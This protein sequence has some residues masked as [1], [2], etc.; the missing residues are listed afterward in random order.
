MTPGPDSLRLPPS[1]PGRSPVRV[2]PPPWGP[3]T[4][5]APGSARLGMELLKDLLGYSLAVSGHLASIYSSKGITCSC[6]SSSGIVCLL[7]A[8]PLLGSF[9]QLWMQGLGPARASRSPSC[10][11]TPAASPCSPPFEFLGTGPPLGQEGVLDGTWQGSRR[12]GVPGLGWRSS[13]GGPGA[14]HLGSITDLL[15]PGVA[16]VVSVLAAQ[17]V[18]P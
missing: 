9:L 11:W 17:P 12:G 15:S 14:E 4:R 13:R 8:D 16:P 18:G 10:S 3:E 5:R 1:Q 6:V 7:R 2:S